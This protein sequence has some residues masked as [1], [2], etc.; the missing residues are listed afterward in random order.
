[1]QSWLWWPRILT[2]STPTSLP[3]LKPLTLFPLVLVFR[4]SRGLSKTQQKH[5]NTSTC[6]LSKKTTHLQSRPQNV[7][8][9]P[10]GARAQR[11]WEPWQQSATKLQRA[12]SRV[13]LCWCSM[14]FLKFGFYYI[15]LMATS[16][17]VLFLKI[18]IPFG[19]LN[20][21]LQNQWDGPSSLSLEAFDNSSVVFVWLV[22]ALVVDSSGVFTHRYRSTFGISPFEQH[23]LVKGAFGQ[24]DP[25]SKR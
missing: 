13:W 9:P 1:M 18:R 14:T 4:P 5:T 16:K 11:P 20:M 2:F 10:T 24:K 25:L 19:L 21:Q 15:F 6:H 17:V 23:A 7:Q 22:L 3:H 8:C 12:L